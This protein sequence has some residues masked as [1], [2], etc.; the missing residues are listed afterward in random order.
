M[1][2]ASLGQLGQLGQPVTAY[3]NSYNSELLFPILRSNNRQNLKSTDFYGV[4]LWHHY[5]V[6]WLDQR[7]VPQVA[8]ARIT[9]PCESLYLIESKSLKLYFNSLNME[10]FESES[11]LKNLIIQDLSKA[12]GILINLEF[13]PVDNFDN[14]SIESQDNLNDLGLCLD[15]LNPYSTSLDLLKLEREPGEI[16]VVHEKLYSNLFRSLCPVTSQPDWARVSIE[17]S[18]AK[19]NH[20]SLLAYLISYRTHQGFHEDCVERIYSDLWNLGGLTSL[21]VIG[22]FTRRGGLDINPMRSSEKNKLIRA[23]RCA[24]Q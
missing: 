11:F 23:R 3:P 15:H 21:T 19:I 8:I 14:F 22:N 9:L 10:K 12:A 13:F 1:H 2:Q 20:E 17:Y 5:E 16:L 7:G 6:S 4:D 24:R 18:G